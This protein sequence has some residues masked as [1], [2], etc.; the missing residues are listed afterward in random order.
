MKYYKK[1]KSKTKS[2]T[3]TKSN[4][5]KNLKKKNN[6]TKKRMYKKKT[7]RCGAAEDKTFNN[8]N[9]LQSYLRNNQWISRVSIYNKEQFEEGN[10]KSMY[11]LGKNEFSKMY[12]IGDLNNY[13]FQFIP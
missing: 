6:I 5:L 3:K 7:K 11:N 12:E 2:K 13:L 1:T 4:K 8:I 10:Y 9:E